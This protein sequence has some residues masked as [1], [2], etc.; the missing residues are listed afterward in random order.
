VRIATILF[1]YHRSFHTRQVLESIRNNTV[2][3]EKLIIFQD[4][5]KPD[6]DDADWKKVNSMIREINWCNK[7]LIV[8]ERNKGLADSVISG[9][10]SVFREYDAVI[11]I[12]DDCVLAP[13]FM[14]FMVQALTRYEQN[15]KVYSVSGYCWPVDLE[16]DQHDAYCCGR[17]SSWG[18][19]TWRGRWEKCRKD[20]DILK[21]L[22][23]DQMKSQNLATW[24]RDLEDMLLGTISGRYD[25][26]GVYWAL[27]VIEN[28]GIC[29][30]PYMPLVK[31]IGWD[32]TG[33]N[34]GRMN[35]PGVELSDT[36]V[37]E[38][39]FPDNLS[40]LDS[41]KRAFVKMFGRHAAVVEKLPFKENVLVYGLGNFYLQNEKAV[42]DMYN[43]E[44]Y[45][46]RKKSGWYA[47]K[48]IITINQITQYV[49]DKILIMVLDIQ[50]CIR[51]AEDLMKC[52]ICAGQIILGNSLY[53]SCM[54]YIDKVTVM[55]ED[56][57]VRL[58]VWV[59]GIMIT[60]R[61]EDEFCNVYDTLANQ[62][63]NY[64]INNGR[65]DVVL[66]VGMNV[67]DSVLYFLSRQNVRKVYGYEPFQK[68]Y[69]DAMENLRDYLQCTERVEIF[70]YGISDENAKRVIGFN[71]DMTCGQSTI[72]DIRE[73][74]YAWYRN[75]G[76]V[77]SEYEEQES[78]QV[79]DAAEV[80]CPIIQFFKDCNIILKMDCEGEE[81]AILERLAEE[82][83]LGQLTMIML[84]WHYRGRDSIL[85]R[86]NE[87]GY[88]Y[89]YQDREGNRGMIYA[90]RI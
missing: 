44:A 23:A 40:I 75:A 26:W 47:G 89:W 88:T 30:N 54:R 58:A 50:E 52:G 56:N 16:R 21:R 57:A 41:T 49:F 35:V 73:D 11:V 2:L 38:Y 72:A 74:A 79:R 77:Q 62:V 39:F 61:S 1:T 66:D 71:K 48:E 32:G 34:T 18:W 42:S 86:L 9:V 37:E 3:P 81:Y 25:S 15:Q 19:G 20:T 65:K 13:G 53:G 70:P 36:G 84:E 76:L 5:L 80:F 6:E 29:I 83:M 33:T 68:T 85:K 59:K 60:I 8:S 55:Q 17:V 46:D 22:K 78:V 51:I 4:G 10:G 87:A 69:A 64:A 24:G 82:Q 43:I 12:D 31:H 28:G 67:G 90:C 14:K 7:E 63:W 45:I 27:H